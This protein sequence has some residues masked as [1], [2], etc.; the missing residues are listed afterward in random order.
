MKNKK[1]I[2]TLSI[3]AI[4]VL[5]IGI[6]YSIFTSSKTSKNSSLVVGDIYM[7]YNETN[8][9]QMENAMPSDTYDATKYFEFTVDGKNTTIDKDVWYEVVLSKGDNLDGKTRIKDNL[10]KFRLTTI[11]N[12]VE[13]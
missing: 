4:L 7:H 11:N 1:I 6:T 2:I 10:L 13:T 9:I 12:S 5:T 3:I 8:Q